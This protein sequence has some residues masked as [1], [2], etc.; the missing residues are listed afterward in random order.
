[1]ALW[2]RRRTGS[3]Q[4]IDLSQFESLVAVTGPALLA[5][6]ALDVAPPGNSSQEGDAAPHGIF[7]CAD[8]P[9]DDPACDRWCAIAV[10]G[11]DDWRRFARV[12]GSPAWMHEQRFATLAARQRHAG[13]LAAHVSDWT[14]TLKAEDVMH[15]LQAAGIAAGV[16]ANA[17][18]L[19]DRDAQ[20]RWRG[21][22]RPTRLS[23]GRTVELDGV[24]V[25]RSHGAPLAATLPAPQIG[26]H[27]AAILGEVLNLGIV[28]IE[29]L[30]RAG[31]VVSAP[32][33]APP[34][35]ESRG[36]SRERTPRARAPDP[37]PR[38]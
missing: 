31:V 3:G 18:D 8:E 9:A 23:D 19:C 26:E 1:M 15:R 16:V 27:S 24:P 7:R 32:P 4:R 20:L 37:R 21:Y 36:T 13:E 11:D 22:W 28:E 25:L 38:I 35:G 5:A 29:E 17:K 30:E 2:V 6:Q 10:F 33:P 34:A 12:L 14:A